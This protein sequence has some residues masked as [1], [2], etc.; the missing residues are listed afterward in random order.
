MK[1]INNQ[2]I[3]TIHQSVPHTLQTP[4]GTIMNAPAL[5]DQELKE[6]GLFDLFLSADYDSRIHELGEIYFDSAAQCY[7]KDIVNKTWTKTI[8]EYKEQAINNYKHSIGSKLSVTD[9][10]IIREMDNGTEVPGDITSQRQ[11]LR[12]TCNEVEQQI[13]DLTTI[14]EIITF[15]YPNID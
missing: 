1:A 7:R 10:Y 11:S 4:T 6:Y 5:T 2:G 9:W 3:I 12:D 8:D 15:N 13:N 14:E